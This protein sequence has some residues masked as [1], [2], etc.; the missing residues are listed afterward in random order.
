LDTYASIEHHVG[1]LKLN[2]EHRY[3]TLTPNYIKNIRRSIETLNQDEIVKVIYMTGAKGEHFSN[4]TDFRTLLHYKKEGEE[5]KIAQYLSDL[6][7][8]QIETSKINKPVI[9]V[10]PG[11]SFNS[12][13]SFL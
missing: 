4:G 7:A 1:Y 2:R 6:Y 11:H 12:G 3:N 10:A 5:A 13:A 9:G 8:L